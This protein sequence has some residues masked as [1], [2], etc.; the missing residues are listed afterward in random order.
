MIYLLILGSFIFSFAMAY[1]FW[2]IISLGDEDQAIIRDENLM[3]QNAEMQGRAVT[4]I[5]GIEIETGEGQ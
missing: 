2:K 1:L 3:V 5:N 4:R